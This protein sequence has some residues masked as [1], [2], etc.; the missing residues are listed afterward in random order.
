VDSAERSAATVRKASRIACRMASS[1]ANVND[2]CPGHDIGDGLARRGL[3]RLTSDISHHA[4]GPST[5]STSGE[6]ELV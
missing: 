1:Y 3:P 4:A 5:S 2:F 6:H